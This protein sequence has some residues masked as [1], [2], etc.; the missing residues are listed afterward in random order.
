MKKL[1]LLFLLASGSIFA[2]SLT[3]EQLIDKMSDVGCE[4]AGK[5]EITKDNLEMTLGLCILE[6][7]NKYEKDV[8]IHY[9]KDVITD[10]KRMESLGY[11]M[12]LK[13]GA[14][15]PTVFKLMM[16]DSNGEVAEEEVVADLM[17][18]GKLTEIKSNQF[19]TFSVKESSG[20]SNNF[21][22][23]NSFENAFLLTDKVLKANDNVDVFY[24][25]SELFDPKAAKFVTYKIVTDIIK[26]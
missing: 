14:K 2:Q 21:L 13:M 10:E 25:E 6:A 15:C 18:S 4:C 3:K 16:N 26:K 9:G 11:D 24:Y 5:Q 8:E 20:K 17:I 22:L 19:L 1:L 12:G 23:L 7:M